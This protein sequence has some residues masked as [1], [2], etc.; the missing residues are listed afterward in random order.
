MIVAFHEGPQGALDWVTNAAIDPA[1]LNSEGKFVF[2]TCQ[3][4]LAR[5]DTARETLSILTDEDLEESP[6]LHRVKAITL[7]LTTVPG[8]FRSVVLNQVPFEAA[9]FPA[10][11]GQCCAEYPPRS[12]A[13]LFRGRGGSTQT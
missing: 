7:L 5:W 2:L 9:S 13:S 10:R 3:L 12:P 8:E 1:E 6:V 11:I 4:E